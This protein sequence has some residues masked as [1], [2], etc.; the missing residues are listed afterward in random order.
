MRGRDAGAEAAFAALVTRHGPMVL[1]VCRQLLGDRHHAEDAF[2]A[3]F[4]VLVRKA[5][6]DPRSRP[7]GKLAL[8]RGP[9]HRPVRPAPGSPVVAGTKSDPGDGPPAPVEPTVP[10]AEQAVQAREQAEA[11]Y[12]EI[13]RLPTAFRLPVVLCYLEGLTVHEAARQ[14]RWPHGTVRSRMA[15]AREK[16]RRGLTRRGIV[17]PAAALAAALSHRSASASVSSPLC[18]MTT[19]AAMSFAAGDAA[20]PAAMALA[21]EVLRSM[22]IHKLKL[23]VLTILFLGA[24]ASGAGFIGQ[25][26]ER[27]AGKP[28]EQDRQAGKPDLRPAPGRMFVVGR[29]LDPQGNPV[30]GAAVMVH[31]RLKLSGR[32]DPY[33]RLSPVPI[34]HMESDGSGRFR[35]DAPRLS[36]SRYDTFYAVALAP[37]YGVGWVELDPDD[38]QPTADIA[39]RPEQVIHGRLFDLQG[40]PARDVSVS[41]F[42]IGRVLPGDP[43]LPRARFEGLSYFWTQINDFPAWP[44]PATTDADGRFTLR[45][46]GRDLRVLLTVNDPRFAL[47][48]IQVET[49][50]TSD[51]KQLTMALEAAQIITGRVTYADTGR[52]VPHA[53]LEIEPILRGAT[54]PLGYETDGEGRFR[55]NPSRGDRCVVKAFPP[56]GQP[57][58]TARQDFEWP[59]GAIEHPVDL[60]L[61]R[62]IVIRGKVTEEGSGKPVAEARVWFHGRRSTDRSN[63]RVEMSGSGPDGSFLLAVPTSPGY[64]VIAGPSDDYVLREIGRRMLDEGLPGGRRMYSHGFI[65]CDPRSGSKGLEI[66]VVLRR[67]ITVQG[68]VL[69]PDGQPTQETWMFSRIML[70]PAPVS[71]RIWGVPSNY[72]TVRNGRF[73][74]HGLDPDI[75]VPVY[76]LEPKRGLGAVAHLSGRSAAGGPVTIRLEP[77][78]TAKAR[79]VDS[80]GKP[81]AGYR[82]S[83]L[84]AFV[85]T[86]GSF[87]SRPQ[88]NDGRLAADVAGLSEMDPINFGNSPVSDAQGRIAIPSLIP[89]A[90]YRVFRLSKEF[91]VKPGETLELGDVRIEKPRPR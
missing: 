64:L 71:W 79:L 67:G 25:A 4:L 45:G 5:P 30:P 53:R 52:P 42:S 72:G 48:R 65:A 83:R 8:R 9:P 14:L 91:T 82:G 63:P 85:V 43:R 74:V 28:D 69:A 40:R 10:P 35:I 88:D 54:R 58:L 34:G 22:L 18:D 76:F 11:L 62:G 41:A 19:R 23:T 55:V 81:I 68:R 80:I 86:P 16:L 29:V 26:P 21:R 73:Q 57:Y 3:V 90:T 2:Q 70:D 66:N 7:A 27:Q 46:V 44:K 12:D 31:A 51:S 15:R 1:G 37:G 75:E 24:V 56:E 20:A 38:D 36:S 89:G 47:Q 60:A 61:S 13:E 17:L 32:G 50:R 84:I 59:K 78:G 77:C 33:A 39:L 6:V 87:S 49:D